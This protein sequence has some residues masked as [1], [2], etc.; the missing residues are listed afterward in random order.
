MIINKP[1][2][3]LHDGFVSSVEL[4]DD[5]II[6]LFEKQNGFWVKERETYYR[7]VN[8]SVSIKL[9][10]EDSYKFVR[11]K[12]YPIL[13]TWIYS[14]YDEITIDELN[15]IIKIE[16]EG[17]QMINDLYN[18]DSLF[19]ISHLGIHSM[20]YTYIEGTEIKYN[21]E[22]LDYSNKMY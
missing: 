22:D 16:N 4:K 18:L 15:R 21:W 8:S 7:A 13:K 17:F 5:H 6:F 2:I 3:A 14:R 12:I 11:K 19:F 9:K 20:C 1:D 10:E